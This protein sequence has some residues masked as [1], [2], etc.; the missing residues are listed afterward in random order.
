MHPACKLGDINHGYV[1][2]P[3]F[4]GYCI[5]FHVMVA[6]INTSGFWIAIMYI[7][8]LVLLTVQ[9]LS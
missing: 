6:I 8:R 4:S 5:K 1:D 3:F 9:F 2:A 7:V